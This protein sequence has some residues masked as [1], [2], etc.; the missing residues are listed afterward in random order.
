MVINGS[1][2]IFVKS[3]LI[4]WYLKDWGGGIVMSLIAKIEQIVHKLGVSCKYLTSLYWAK[5]NQSDQ[6]VFKFVQNL[7]IFEKEA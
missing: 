2:W 1:G 7:I 4:G 6:F 5:I 3:V